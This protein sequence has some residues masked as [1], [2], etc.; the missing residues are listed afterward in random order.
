MRDRVHDEEARKKQEERV[1]RSQLERM[2]KQVEKI[3]GTPLVQNQPE[4]PVGQFVNQVA[5]AFLFQED[6]LLP[7]MKGNTNANSKLRQYLE[8]IENFASGFVIGASGT[9][10]IYNADGSTTTTTFGGSAICSQTIQKAITSTF[11]TTEFLYLFN[12]STAMEFVL[13]WEKA[14]T[15]INEAYTYCNFD[16]YLRGFAMLFGEKDTET[17]LKELQNH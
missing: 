13:K 12:P 9:N 15:D 7:H 5:R 14:Q 11:D 2:N 4:G 3:S 17:T 6:P 8:N 16:R 10:K 1:T